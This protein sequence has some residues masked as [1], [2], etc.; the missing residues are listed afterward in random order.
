MQMA[1]PWLQRGVLIVKQVVAIDLGAS[2]GCLM[3]VSLRNGKI[4][5]KEIHRF[6]NEIIEKDGHLYWDLQMIFQE[7]KTGL[8]KV[9]GK[10]DSLGV[11]TWGVDFGIIGKDGALLDRP[12]S[13]RD[14]HTV[15]VMKAVHKNVENKSI[16]QRTGVESAALN[17]LYQ[18]K[19]IYDKNPEWIEKTDSIL[20]FP[21]L[22]NYLLTG[23]KRNEFT[24]AS[25]T[26]M[27]STITKDW[28]T[29]L[30]N[31]VYGFVPSMA[32][33]QK[34]TTVLGNTIPTVHETIGMGE[35]T[36]VQVPG[37][38]TA[39]ALAAI[40]TIDRGSAFMS[41]GTWVLVGVE[42]D[43]PV[44]TDE[45][46]EWGFTNEGTAEGTYRL[47]KNNMG[48]WLLQQCKRE[49]KEDG[50][51]I[52]YE[53]EASFVEVTTPF[54]SFIDPD[55]QL[56]FNPS[57]MVEAIKQ[58]CKKTDQPIPQTKGEILRCIL[59]SLAMKYRWV[60]NRMEFLTNTIIPE[61][62]MVG[63]G[64]QNEFLC[65]FTANATR[66]E[67]QAGPIEASSIGNALSQFIALDEISGWKEAKKVVEN[68]FGVQQFVSE[69][70]H[71][72]EEAY[73]R[74]KTFLGV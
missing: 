57:S 18:V 30:L 70:V 11:D 72:W 8:K 43:E 60:L 32:P 9:E 44:V 27:L 66:K 16:F 53:E 21:S 10:I 33:L 47:Q 74:F 31:D 67:V 34:T 5:Q 35:T 48:L 61:V 1:I 28:D 69:D 15:Q 51:A 39:C 19:A 4:T 73:E 29:A 42:V 62:H 14:T 50:E 68:S 25:T 59:E 71:E 58:F 20:T 37:H 45:A 49:W 17:T 13:Y 41:C 36:V 63:G 46:H 38:D 23:K 3:L 52:S 55:D 40:P 54:R 12:Y 2:N 64:I 6:P 22:I 65:Q 26:Q 7:I 56:F 24:H